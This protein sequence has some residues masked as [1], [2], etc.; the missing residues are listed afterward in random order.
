M[1][2]G[3]DECLKE[4]KFSKIFIFLDYL[5]GPFYVG[6]KLSS[7]QRFWSSPGHLS[8]RYVPPA[9][10]DGPAKGPEKKKKKIT[11]SPAG[12]SL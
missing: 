10:A 5:S 6:M 4:D 2:S 8:F 1:K 3:Q 7:S 12:V 11:G 9:S